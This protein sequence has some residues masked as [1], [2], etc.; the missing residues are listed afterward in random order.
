MGWDDGLA[1]DCTNRYQ[2]W[3]G[4]Q[5]WAACRFQEGARA[6]D[7]APVRRPGR[8]QFKPWLQE[9]GYSALARCLKPS[10]RAETC[11]SR[12]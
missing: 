8:L 7:G 3:V 9:V 6:R 12:N 2:D 10:A 11:R 1:L 4:V 5:A